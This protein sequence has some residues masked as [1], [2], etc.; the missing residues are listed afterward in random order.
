[1]AYVCHRCNILLL[2]GLQICDVG[3]NQALLSE[4]HRTATSDLHLQ[5]SEAQVNL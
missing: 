1:M 2:H 5:S 4:F 3:Q